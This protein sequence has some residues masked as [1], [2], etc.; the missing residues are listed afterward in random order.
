MCRLSSAS[1]S[2]SI[3]GVDPTSRRLG[4]TSY[5][6][7]LSQSFAASLFIHMSTGSRISPAIL[8]LGALP[9][10]P[11]HISKPLHTELIAK[12][13][14]TPSSLT[15]GA[16]LCLLR[17]VHCYQTSSSVPSLRP[18]PLH[19]H[20]HFDRLMA[21]TPLALAL[22]PAFLCRAADFPSFIIN[23]TYVRALFRLAGQRLPAS[24]R[25]ADAQMTPSSV[26]SA[27][28]PFGV[29]R[30]LG[31]RAEAA[32]LGSLPSSSPVGVRVP[33]NE[34]MSPCSS[35][36]RGS[37][38]RSVHVWEALAAATSLHLY[39]SRTHPRAPGDGAG[40]ADDDRVGT[41]RQRRSA[42]TRVHPSPAL[43]VERRPR[44]WFGAPT[45]AFALALPTL[46]LALLPHL[47]PPLPLA[48]AV[49]YGTRWLRAVPVRAR[50]RAFAEMEKRGCPR[51]QILPSLSQ[52]LLVRTC[53]P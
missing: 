47:H 10:S 19:I 12:A 11:L 50:T 6:D 49:W 3:P 33:W 43:T 5:R 26:C 27:R 32:F 22:A 51:E 40:D 24:F 21:L 37:A 41:R 7:S 38:V 36:A 25:R 1:V 2:T 42:G 39:I 34:S 9:A 46:A 31:V 4:V 52:S 15:S 53:L 14:A 30:A 29:L 8:V 23:H 44:L 13:T 16:N 18:I 48:P 45:L 20:A 35:C 28:F 17:I